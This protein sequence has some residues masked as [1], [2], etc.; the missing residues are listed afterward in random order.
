MKPKSIKL[1]TNTILS[2]VLAMGIGTTSAFA[3][4][5]QTAAHESTAPAPV[6]GSTES[7]VTTTAPQ[8]NLS[9]LP[10]DFF[11]LFKTIVIKIEIV[12]TDDQVKQAKLHS[13]ITQE[14]IKR[15]EVLIIKGKTDLAVETLQQSVAEQDQEIEE[16]LQ[17]DENESNEEIQ[18]QLR[19]NIEALT[20]VMAKVKN[21]KAK[22]ALAKNIKKSKAKLLII[23]EQPGEPEEQKTGLTEVEVQLQAKPVKTEQVEN[24]DDQKRFEDEDK[25]D[26][27]DSGDKDEDRK[28]MQEKMKSERKAAQEQYKHDR[29]MAH[30]QSKKERKESHEKSKGDN[31]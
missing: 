3:N 31:K 13:V 22:A 30:E 14:R 12:L 29:K 28:A 10:A 4:E 18:D 16:S 7:S 24:D 20:I 6:T 26:D 23:I 21:P 25:N 11:Y 5:T 1:I 8:S 19:H 15:A 9:E 27:E 17:S 2:A